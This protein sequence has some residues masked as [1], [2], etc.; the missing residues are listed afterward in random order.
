MLLERNGSG[1]FVA[2]AVNFGL[3]FGEFFGVVFVTQVFTGVAWEHCVNAPVGGDF[4]SV[5]NGA[6]LVGFL[7]VNIFDTE[8]HGED[9]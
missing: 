2:D 5:L 3:A 7:F 8:A 4:S 1:C 9:L 6:D